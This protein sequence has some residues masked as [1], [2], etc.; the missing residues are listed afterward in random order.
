MK[1]SDSNVRPQTLLERVYAGNSFSGLEGARTS[2]TRRGR[3]FKLVFCQVGLF[4]YTVK[5]QPLVLSCL[6]LQSIH[7]PHDIDNR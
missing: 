6:T 5:S 2:Q 4:P 1:V 7:H 3:R